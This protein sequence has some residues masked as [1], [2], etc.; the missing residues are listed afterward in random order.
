M[1]RAEPPAEHGAGDVRHQE[2]HRLGGGEGL[3]ER[4]EGVGRAGAGRDEDDARLARGAGIAVGHERRALLVPREH[5]G[6]RRLAE[7]GVVDGQVVDARNA[8]DVADALGGES[9]HHP[10]SPCPGLVLI[11]RAHRVEGIGAD[12]ERQADGPSRGAGSPHGTLAR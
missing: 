1:E 6:D 8:E 12:P 2:E 3:H 11:R 5:V 4:G 10:L 7:Q 9:R